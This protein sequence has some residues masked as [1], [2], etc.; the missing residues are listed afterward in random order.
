MNIPVT[1]QVKDKLTEENL[2]NSYKD[3]KK[4]CDT[5]TISTNHQVGSRCHPGRIIYI[6]QGNWHGRCRKPRRA[7][8]SNQFQ[9]PFVV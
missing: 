5:S 4:Q 6:L 7:P 1:N 3:D 8:K 9:L 2:S